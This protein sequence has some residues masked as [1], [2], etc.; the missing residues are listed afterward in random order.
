M[1]KKN[2]R[3][4][5][6][7]TMRLLKNKQADE[8]DVLKDQFRITYESLKPINVIKSSLHEIA[9]SPDI[10]NN[11]LNNAIGLGMGYLAKKLL[12]GASHYPIKKILGTLLQFAVTN[13]VAKYSH[14]FNRKNNKQ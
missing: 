5:L 4:A 6:H 14:H 10:K 12:V 9:T 7:E 1:K 3:E 11:L 13:V 2:E 8:L